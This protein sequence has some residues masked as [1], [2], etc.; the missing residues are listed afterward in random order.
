M[1][2]HDLNLKG[3]RFHP[4][5]AYPPLVVHPN[6]VLPQAIAGERL[7][8]IP[9]N[10]S[11]IEYRRRRMDLIQFSLGDAC[12]PLKL[13]AELPP[14]IFPV[15]LSRNDR[16]KIQITTVPRLTQLV[17]RATST[18]IRRQWLRNRLRPLGPAR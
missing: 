6:A 15:S 5:E 13:P 9:G 18:R 3:I 12:N 17:K 4:A 1:V 11:E 14:E 10:R 7:Q 8:T 2:V 16:I